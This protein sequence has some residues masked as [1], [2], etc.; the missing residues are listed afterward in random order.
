[1]L[2]SIIIPVYNVADYLEP[3]LVSVLTNDCGDSEIILVDDGSTDGRSGPLC[4]ELAQRNPELIRVI[5]QTNKGLG[6]ARNTGIEAAR[7]EYLLFLDSD[8]AIVPHMLDTLRK[9]IEKWQPDVITF[10]VKCVDENG[11]ELSVTRHS[12][13]TDRTVSLAEC[14]ALILDTPSTPARLWRRRLFMD[15]GIRFPNRLWYEDLH[16]TANLLL[17]AERIIGLEESLY[18]YLQRSGSIMHSSNPNRIGEI[19]T[20]LDSVLNYYRDKGAAE[21]YQT[22]LEAMVVENI[23]FACYRLLRLD[24]KNP[25]MGQML[26]YLNEKSPHYKQSP[27]YGRLTKAQRLMLELFRH[28]IYALPQFLFACKDR[29]KTH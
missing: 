27:Y 6:G 7:G 10:W 19:M 18:L 21:R 25:L 12:A 1:M 3:C 22:E 8:D 28:H 23:Y 4:D 20:A 24:R 11:A 2:F 9:T 15:S 17:G 29:M 16:T 13:P 5:H 14:P 26:A